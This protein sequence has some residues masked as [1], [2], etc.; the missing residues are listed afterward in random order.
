V[1]FSQPVTD[2][3]V[4]SHWCARTHFSERSGADLIG[5]SAKAEY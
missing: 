1:M 5:E 4:K 2:L 3:G